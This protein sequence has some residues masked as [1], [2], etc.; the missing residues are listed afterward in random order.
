[1]LRFQH[2]VTAF[3]AGAQPTSS[4]FKSKGPSHAFVLP[5]LTVIGPAWEVDF[6]VREQDFAVRLLSLI[7]AP[8]SQFHP[9]DVY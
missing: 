5:L 8:F 2:D 9:S 3:L 4:T 6:M 1:M 7:A